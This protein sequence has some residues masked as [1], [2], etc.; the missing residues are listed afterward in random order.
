MHRRSQFFRVIPRDSL[1]TVPPISRQFLRFS[2]RNGRRIKFRSLL[3]GQ[4]R[5]YDTELSVRRVKLLFSYDV[6]R[7]SP[8]HAF[9][10]VKRERKLA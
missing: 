9:P 7:Q 1:P 4:L 6:P 3:V 5:N 8:F 2:G 10:S